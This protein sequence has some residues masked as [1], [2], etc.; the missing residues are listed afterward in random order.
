MNISFLNQKDYERLQ[1]SNLDLPQPFNTPFKPGLPLN[2][3]F[4][5][6]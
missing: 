1:E 5:H 3:S 4:G 2:E 6:R